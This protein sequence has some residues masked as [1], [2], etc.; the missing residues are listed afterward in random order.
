MLVLM[1]Y[2]TQSMLLWV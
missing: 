2:I 1:H